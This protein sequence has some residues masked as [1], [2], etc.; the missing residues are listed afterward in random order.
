MFTFQVIK[1]FSGQVI[2]FRKAL[3]VDNY[4]TDE[5]NKNKFPDQVISY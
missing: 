4:F 1:S 5:V 2:N 3:Q